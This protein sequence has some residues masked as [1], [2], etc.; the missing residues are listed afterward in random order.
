MS[1]AD[2]QYCELTL[3]I[4]FSSIGDIVSKAVVRHTSVFSTVQSAYIP[5]SQVFFI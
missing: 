5:Y 3:H 1:V 2:S 4:Q